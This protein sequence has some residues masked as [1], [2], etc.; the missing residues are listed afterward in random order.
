MF[1]WPTPPPPFSAVS[2]SD[3]LYFPSTLP[4]LSHTPVHP[5]QI[6]L[7]STLYTD[8]SRCL[9]SGPQCIR[10]LILLYFHISFLFYAL[11]CVLFLLIS[12]Y[13]CIFDASFPCVLCFSGSQACFSFFTCLLSF[14][15]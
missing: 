1:L 9:C 3:F 13:T 4:A 6:L 10:N 7:I 15:L 5:E 14:L 11:S 2:I 8:L 12:I